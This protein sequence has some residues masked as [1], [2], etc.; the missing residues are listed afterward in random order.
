MYK[1]STADPLCS[2]DGQL[3]NDGSDFPEGPTVCY[4][5]SIRE[6]FLFLFRS[7][8]LFIYLSFLFSFPQIVSF[9]SRC[10]FPFF[11]SAQQHIS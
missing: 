6:T 3:M 9:I 1:C 5:C 7:S 8:D 4:T 11:F 10:S 2:D